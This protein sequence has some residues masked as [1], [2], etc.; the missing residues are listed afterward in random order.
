MSW[1]SGWNAQLTEPLIDQ[2]IAIVNRDMQSALDWVSGVP[3][4]LPAFIEY[5]LERVP[6]KNFPTLLLTPDMESFDEESTDI[7][8]QSIRISGA[9]AVTHQVPNLL[10]RLLQRYFR[11]FYAVLRTS[12]L[13]TSGDWALS[14]PLP[15]GLQNAASAGIP[16]GALCNLWIDSVAYDQFRQIRESVFAQALAFSIV[17]EMEEQ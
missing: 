6:I 16:A 8:R 17:A 7:V 13:R 3:G 1:S 12:W 15:A 11:A 9:I 10:A 5:D 14:L 2:I 4:S